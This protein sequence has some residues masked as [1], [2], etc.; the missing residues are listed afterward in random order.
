MEQPWLRARATWTNI[1]TG[2]AGVYTEPSKPDGGSIRMDDD[3]GSWD[4]IW[5][6]GNYSCDD[7]RAMFFEGVDVEEC[8]EDTYRID[9]LEVLDESGAVVHTFE[10]PYETKLASR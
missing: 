5:R 3:A 10:V 4:Y 9:K 2:A 8:S 7:N 1:K 6:E